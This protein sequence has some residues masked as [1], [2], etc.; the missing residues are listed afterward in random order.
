MSVKDPAIVYLK[1]EANELVLSDNEGHHSEKG[2]Q[3]DFTTYVAPNGKIAWEIADKSIK[4]IVDIQID[5]NKEMFKKLPHEKKGIW[6]AK[7]DNKR[8]QHSKYSVVFI[9]SGEKESIT[10]DPKI[11]IRP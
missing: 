7:I 1:Y 6:E 8:S 2:K 4:E 3:K 5:T 11:E 9:P 10:V